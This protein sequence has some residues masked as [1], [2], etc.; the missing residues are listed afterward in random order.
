LKLQQESEDKKNELIINDL[1]KKVKNLEN[2]LEEKDS[3]LKAVK[4][5]LLKLTFVT[6][7]KS[8]KFLIRTK[9]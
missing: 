6:K 7:I 3:K 1:E 2:M 9:N 4:A 5:I 8:Y